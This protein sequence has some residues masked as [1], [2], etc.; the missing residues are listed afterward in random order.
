MP[1]REMIPE[2]LAVRIPLAME[3]IGIRRSKLYELIKS[4]ELRTVKVGRATLITMSS[5][6]RL[7]D[8]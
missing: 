4:G 8:R 7:V 5:L 2:P 6:R 3:L 1:Y